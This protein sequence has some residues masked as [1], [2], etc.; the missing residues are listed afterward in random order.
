MLDN[1][2]T[3][4]IKFS[5]AGGTVR[6]GLS[7]HDR[8]VD[9]S[10]SD[11]GPGIDPAQQEVVFAPFHRAPGTARVPGVGLGLAIVKQ[12]VE[13]HGGTVSLVSQRGQGATFTVR[14]PRPTS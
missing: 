9:I 14:L 12:I 8:D 11:Q 2:L 7:V 5:P 13:R 1:L 3:N 4:A 10:I 6:V